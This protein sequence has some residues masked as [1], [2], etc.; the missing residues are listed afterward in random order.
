[1]SANSDE[2]K[3]LLPGKSSCEYDSSEPKT[4]D[5]AKVSEKSDKSQISFY[6]LFKEYVIRVFAGLTVEALKD[7]FDNLGF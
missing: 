7:W 2:A 4:C 3:K 1:M 6:S 5:G